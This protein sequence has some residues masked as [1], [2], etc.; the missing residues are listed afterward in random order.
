MFNFFK[1][2]MTTKTTQ[3]GILASEM[4]VDQLRELAIQL[5]L[6]DKKV[7]AK[8]TKPQLLK[9]IHTWEK[10]EIAKNRK[11]GMKVLKSVPEKESPVDTFNGKVVISRSE[12]EINGKTYEDVQVETGEVFT[13]LKA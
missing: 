8:M 7:V 5:E 3:E 6:V 2:L 4:K 9:E 12:R 13:N 10:K 1:K 11:N